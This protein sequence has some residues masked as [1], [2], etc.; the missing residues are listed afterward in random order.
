[1]K[2][3]VQRKRA[4]SKVENTQLR[5]DLIANGSHDL[6]TPLVSSRGYLDM[7]VTKVNALPGAQRADFLAVV[8]RQ[9]ESLAR[10]IEALFDLAKPDFKGMAL[11]RELLALTELAADVLKKFQLCANEHDVRP[12]LD[13]APGLPFVFDRYQCSVP[14]NSGATSRAV[15]RV[16]SAHLMLYWEISPAL[17]M[18]SPRRSSRS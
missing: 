14:M 7:L 10:R 9:S 17:T 12:Q 2:A 8:L 18:I 4:E 13:S 3:E 15:C 5:R 6:G 16:G 1:M 11:Q